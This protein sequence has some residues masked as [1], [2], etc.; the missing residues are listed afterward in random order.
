M[1]FLHETNFLSILFVLLAAGIQRRAIITP[2]R[3]P[4]ASL[5]VIEETF[6]QYYLSTGLLRATLDFQTYYFNSLTQTPA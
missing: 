4:A 3:L 6:K 5:S 2:L 1:L